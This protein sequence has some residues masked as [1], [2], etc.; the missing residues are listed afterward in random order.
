MKKKRLIIA[1]SLIIILIGVFIASLFVNRTSIQVLYE[2]GQM[3]VVIDK[4]K[5]SDI[6][7]IDNQEVAVYQTVSGII[8]ICYESLNLDNEYQ[9]EII[10][11]ETK[12]IP[13]TSKTN[14]FGSYVINKI[15][16]LGLNVIDG[17]LTLAI[18]SG[19]NNG[20]NY[21]TFSLRNL[22]LKINKEEIWSNEYP[23]KDYFNENINF[24]EDDLNP[25]VRLNYKTM[26][27]LTFDINS[28]LLD[29]IGSI[30][31]E[32][33]LNEN[34]NIKYDNKEKT[35]INESQINLQCNIK[36]GEIINKTK[37]LE[38]SK[39][40]NITS[41]VIKMDGINIDNNLTFN[42]KAWAIGEHILD[43]QATNK[44]GFKKVQ[45]ISFTLAPINLSA[46]SVYYDIYQV[47]V[48]EKLFQGINQI[49]VMTNDVKE[50][51]QEIDENYLTTPYSEAPVITFV[52][53][54]DN[55]TE[56]S[57]LGKITIGRTAFM[58][59]YNHEK[60]NWETVSTKTAFDDEF[61]QLGFD[62]QGLPK[63]ELEDKIYIRISTTTTS[64]TKLLTSHQILHWTD[65][66]YIIQLLTLSNQDSVMWKKAK[67]CLDDIV[68]YIIGEYQNNNL[69]YLALTGDMVQQQKGVNLD[70][71]I[72]FID[73][74]LNPLMK[75]GVPLGLSSGNHDVGGV[76]SYN[77]D[78]AN[79]L[80]DALTYDYYY[81]YVGEDVFKELEYYGGSYKNNRSH[82]DLITI[83]GHE[84]LFL[85]LGWGS[86]TRY[87][88][89]SDQDIDW[90]KTVLEQFPD[91]T[92]ILATHEYMGNK[93]KRSFTGEYVYSA[94]VKKYANIQFV[95]SGHIN[96]SSYLIDELDDN[97]DGIM[98]RTV[99]Q[100]L[101]DFQEEEN[102]FGAS[103]C[104]MI[105]LDF[106]N[107][108]MYFNIYSPYYKDYDIFV[109]ENIEYVK[110]ASEFYYAFDLSNSG[111]GILTNYFG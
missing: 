12:S 34:F 18:K 22:F 79:A 53:R 63:Y 13:L 51:T 21:N 40:H 103:F 94:L 49:G 25:D 69:M 47:G 35:F 74:V 42:E 16:I 30:I 68:A 76:S 7:L 41:F 11:N 73:Y 31:N 70:E 60:Q 64:F 78:G 37:T 36:D 33:S 2:N 65:M 38:I 15:K 17:K 71:W 84:F 99:L 97:G 46:S 91:K 77:P 52:V 58:Q 106:N 23:K 72:N 44:Y 43:I 57:W 45:I 88:H 108:Y 39:D 8:E 102:L 110:K 67:K 1:S 10:I 54:K 19:Q 87:I 93:G 27:V 3:G 107:N 95:I 96:G 90:A 98:D 61:I 100:L 111:F 14:Q 29:I 89:V 48:S 66:Q 86:S 85:Y 105:Q 32:E 26:E 62:Y 50:L 82:Y 81:Q 9:N 56:F 80:D 101:T 5:A 92:V 109:N 55:K 104:R 75:A 28:K 24:G 4:K 20:K 59:I 6:I 83:N